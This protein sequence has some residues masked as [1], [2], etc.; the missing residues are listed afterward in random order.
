[1]RFIGSK[2]LLLDKIKEVIDENVKNN[3]VN[4]CDI[5]SGTASVARYFKRYYEIYSNDIMNFSYVLQKSTIENDKIPDFIILKKRG[6]DDPISYLESCDISSI[7]FT[8]NKFFISNNY[9]PNKKCS[10]MYLTQENANRIDFIRLKLEEWKL[11]KLINLEEY[12]YLLACLIEGIPYVSNISGTYGAFFKEWDKRALNKFRMKRLDVLTNSKNNRCY[13]KD[14]N[15]LI[16]EIKGDILYIDPP[17]NSRQYI[18]NYHLLETISKYDYPNIYGVTGLRPYDGQKS[19]YCNKKTAANAFEDLIKNAQFK[20]IIVSYSTDGLMSIEEIECILKKY[21]NHKTYKLYKIPYRKY[22]SKQTQKIIEL[23]ELIFFIEKDIKC[24][25]N[26]NKKNKNSKNLKLN[27]YKSKN[28]KYIKSPLNYIG[29][30]YKILDQI[31]PL[32]PKNINTFVDLFAGGLNVSINVDSKK[33]IANDYNYFIIELFNEFNNKSKEYVINHITSRID[34]FKL[35]KFNEEGFKKFRDF[36]NQYKNPLDLYTLVCYS[37]NYQFR[38]NNKLEY[39][40]PFGRN[41][42]QFSNTLMKKLEIF[43]DEIHI[44]NIEFSSKD[45]LDFPL[46][47]LSSNDLIYC[48]PPYLITTG[49]YNDG[50]RGFKNW[51]EY[52]E[53]NLLNYLDKA[54]KKGIKFALSNVLE[55][56][57]KSNDILKSWSQKYNIVYLNSNYSNSS[58]NTTKGDSL[59]VLIINY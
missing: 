57:G 5:F 40:N 16:K 25:V 35:S 50:N 34:E 51:D 12:N 14:A 33:V 13:N 17:Y 38:F 36:Y 30:K 46:E 15:E 37:F 9:A 47:K 22:K 11:S 3:V 54:N 44:K 48:D 24:N 56:K 55:H 28:K 43:L 8:N 7:D 1:M 20:Y 26:D 27:K 10:R 4:F 31:I 21:G 42:S 52:Q 39:N 23:Y 18:P 6:I 45:F 58:Y 2:V 19:Q 59:E 41:R 32:F 29:G 49:S 53:R